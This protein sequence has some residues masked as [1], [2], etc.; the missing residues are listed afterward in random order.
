MIEAS[1]S[2]VPFFQFPRL[3]ADPRVVHAISARGRDQ[4]WNMSFSVSAKHG[5]AA[6]S[7]EELLRA[8]H[9]PAG[10]LAVAGQVHGKQVAV[11]ESGKLPADPK[12]RN[13]SLFLETDGLVTE[14]PGL[15]LLVTAADCPPVFLF[16][17]KRPAI[18]IVHSG[19][20]GTW[21]GISGEAV[22]LMRER[23][24][25]RPEQLQAAV[26]PGIG[27]CCYEVGDELISKLTP[28]D[29]KHLLRRQESWVL[30]LTSWIVNQLREAGLQEPAIERSPYCTSCHRNHFFSH[31]AEKG[32]TG[33]VA[34]VIALR[35]EK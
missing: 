30:D 13:Q 2:T 24:G 11:V 29:R 33:R 19:W 16:D 5:D 12:Q 15:T 4:S 6:R 26:G 10:K 7:R 8:L 3:A 27:S 35:P 22:A 14:E 32:D 25:S 23:F 34:A 17:P 9:L 18:G 28:R 21:A 1:S 31:R 20:R